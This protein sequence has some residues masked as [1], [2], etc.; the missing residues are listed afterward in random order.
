MVMKSRAHCKDGKFECTGDHKEWCAEMEKK[1]A[2]KADSLDED[3]TFEMR[4][5]KKNTDHKATCKNGHFECAGDDAWCAEQ[6]KQWKTCKPLSN[7]FL[8]KY[9]RRQRQLQ[10]SVP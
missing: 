10:A 8:E 5:T 6:Q 3:M 1:C 7:L 2:E 4:W 9:S